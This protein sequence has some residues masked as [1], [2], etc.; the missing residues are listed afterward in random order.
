[1]DAI[2]IFDIA[3]NVLVSFCSAP[4]LKTIRSNFVKH[5]V[6]CDEPFFVD[7]NYLYCYVKDYAGLHF[8]TVQGLEKKPNLL[9]LFDYIYGWFLF[10]Y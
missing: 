3:C 9:Q 7:S 6:N 2:V 4:K 5:L 10:L 1:M 8:L